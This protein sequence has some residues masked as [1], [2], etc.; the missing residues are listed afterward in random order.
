MTGALASI[1]VP[2]A[3]VTIQARMLAFT[4]NHDAN[5]LCIKDPDVR[6]MPPA[7]PGLPACPLSER[8]LVL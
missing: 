5:R 8:I 6:L 3:P 4:W 2:L 1:A 7:T